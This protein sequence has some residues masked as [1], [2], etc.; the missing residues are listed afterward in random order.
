M[1]KD[2]SSSVEFLRPP[3]GPSS[4]DGI[5]GEVAESLAFDDPRR[6]SALIR[7]SDMRRAGSLSDK[8]FSAAVAAESLT[9][10]EIIIGENNILPAW[11][12]DV[13]PTRSSAVC[14]IEAGGTNYK[15]GRGRWV[16]TGFL[17][18]DS[19]LLTNHHVI[20][21]PDTARN[22]ECVFNYQRD[23]EGKDLPVKRFRLNPGRLFLTSPTPGGLDFTFVWV[24]GA[25]GKEFGIVPFNRDF[26]VIQE[27]DVANIIQHPGGDYKGVTLQENKVMR[28]DEALVHYVSDTK[29][30]SSGSCVFNNSWMPFA[31]HHASADNASP[32]AANPSRY[33]NEGIRF[34]AIVA[35]L[36]NLMR[37]EPARRQAVE[38]ILSHVNGTDSVLGHWGAL[39]RAAP[40]SR[41]AVETV[42]NIYRG[43]AEDVDV[44]FWNVG[45]FT[46]RYSEKLQRVA[47]VFVKMNLDIWV[48]EETTAEAAGALAAYLRDAYHLDFVCE[49]SEP[50]PQPGAQTTAVMWNRKTVEGRKAEWP[51]EI[52]E[53]FSAR[54]ED[55]DD[56]RREGAEG[57]MFERRPAL[58]RFSNKGGAAF[59]FFLAPLHLKA[60]DGGG[61]RRVAAAILAAA[62]GRMV[63]QQGADRDWVIGGDFDAPLANEDFGKLVAGGMTA[64]SAGGGQG[65]AFSYVKGPNSPV[66]HVFLSPNLS[67]TYGG[68]DFFIVARDKEIPDYLTALGGHSPVL[69][70]LSIRGD[71]P[72]NER[73]HMTDGKRLSDSLRDK[74][75]GLDL[76][77]GVGSARPAPD[78]D[79]DGDG[80]GDS[81]ALRIPLTVTVSGDEVSLSARIS[82]R[83]LKGLLAGASP[84][85]V[86]EAVS[87]DPDYGSR[88]GYDPDFLG[89]GKRRVPLPQLSAALKA[90]AAVNSKAAGGDRHV[91]PYHHYSVVMNRERRLAFFTAVN[92]DGSVFYNIKREPDKWYFDPRIGKDE[93]TGNEVYANNPLDRGHLVRRL[94][95]AWG[96][97]RELAKVANDDTF[98]FTNCSP[99]HHDFNA[100][101]SLWAG[102]EDYI[103][104]NADA[105]DFKVSVFTGPVFSKDDDAYRGVQL[106]RQF[107]KVVVMVKGDG[108]LSATGYLLSQETLLQGIGEEAFVP[109]DK[110]A[111]SYGAYKTF[112]TPV[113]RIEKL[114]GLSFGQLRNFDPKNHLESDLEG[115]EALDLRQATLDD[116]KDIKF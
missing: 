100:G 37:D 73:G 94:D 11:F 86:E 79:G 2:L 96:E 72:K 63:E 8:G 21:S 57:R 33:V 42:V 13:A 71:Q 62:V 16:G 10:L 50:D 24:E 53:W 45:W 28:V 4:R 52:D 104:K 48:F 76:G 29:P 84:G 87:I 34:S 67:E 108:K 30:G 116:Y 49:F 60:Q 105:L 40:D 82:V 26:F 31:L 80:D 90:R 27:G 113:R 46:P 41:P 91:L 101:K 59:D 6:V 55:F 107:W 77:V 3:V 85:V 17:I 112:Q 7:A 20:N 9:S 35:Y 36:E 64:L 68:E 18:S 56:L 47:E 115:L 75:S 102:L 110:E 74:L 23:P 66:E 15:G 111:F 19:V 14:K 83:E 106:P 70:R 95:P 58:F 43:E 39:G 92:I 97:S 69:V 114:T 25:P 99:Q 51:A 1:P 32:G 5:T 109:E 54:A 44:G 65:G 22:A 61:K 89:A 93:Q 103:L 88:Q 98:H 78:A 38:E 81:A 12:L